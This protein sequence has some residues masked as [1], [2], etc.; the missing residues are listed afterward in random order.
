MGNAVPRSIVGGLA[1]AAMLAAAA[2]AVGYRAP[3]NGFGQPDLEGYWTNL[4]LTVLQ[5]PKALKGLAVSDAEA[6]AYEKQ[7]AAAPEPDDGVG[8]L[9]TDWYD[10]GARLARI[11]GEA[12]SSWIVDPPDGRLPYSTVGRATME[13]WQKRVRTSFAGPET[14]TMGE[15]CLLSTAGT[16]G[17]PMLNGRYNS[18]YQIVQGP[19]A[20]AILVEMNHDV[21]IVRLGAKHHAPAAVRPWMGDS[22]GWWDR[23]TLVVETTNLNPGEALKA[24]GPL[25]LSPAAKVIERFTRVSPRQILYQFSVDDP[26][27][28][29]RTW[30]GEMAL[31]AAKGP[32]YEYACHEGNR[33]LPAI[34]A[35]ARRAERDQQARGGAAVQTAK[36]P[37]P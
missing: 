36:R 18:N 5:R 22:V 13:A 3:R 6:A 10:A 20:V 32:I 2:H 28:Y 25:Y 37:A 33:S 8:G 31:N 35:G 9:E 1:A 29:T 24:N 19:D 7:R 4:S 26:A 15:R 21:R 12:R 16:D 23:D 27:T 11:G 34:L 14:R 17:P 30:R